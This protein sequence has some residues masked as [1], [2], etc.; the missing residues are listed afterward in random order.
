MQPILT[1]L[2]GA[3]GALWVSE[4]AVF[5]KYEVDVQKM[6]L[7]NRMEAYLDYMNKPT[8]RGRY[9]LIL[10]GNSKVIE[11]MGNIYTSF[12]QDS[13]IGECENTCEANKAFVKL[14]KAMR[15]DFELT[16]GDFASEEDIFRAHY[17]NNPNC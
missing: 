5:S 6:I 1:A 8:D 15:D 11:S 2:I 12:C 17:E 3:A 7:N 13:S 9:R 10:L 16:S 14:Y 4:S